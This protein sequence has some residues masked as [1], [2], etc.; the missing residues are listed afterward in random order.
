MKIIFLDI[1][2]VL[3]NDKDYEDSELYPCV[4]F[5]SKVEL[6][7]KVHATFLN[8]QYVLATSWRC[9][10]ENSHRDIREVLQ[11]HG[12]TGKFHSDWRT[13]W[14]GK[15]IVRVDGSKGEWRRGDEVH[16]W[17]WKNAFQSKYVI[18]DDCADFYPGQAHIKTDAWV[19]L[20]E[21]DVAQA[22]SVL[23][24]DSG[25]EHL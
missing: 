15:D 12:F 6:L 9:H 19:G 24:D 1:D 25:K 10:E 22:I 16:S 21:E 23:T 11:E 2:G 13:P 7:N 17:L 18:L 8:V 4:I 14:E 20:T 5:P 3:N